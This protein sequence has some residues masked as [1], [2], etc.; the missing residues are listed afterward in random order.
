MSCPMTIVN[1]EFYRV[2][3]DEA[4]IFCCHGCSPGCEEEFL[5]KFGDR[6]S[7]DD[8]RKKWAYERKSKRIWN[9]AR[10]LTANYEL[11]RL[12]KT[13]CIME[14]GTDVFVEGADVY[15]S[16]WWPI[17]RDAV[18]KR[19]KKICRICGHNAE[20][21]RALGKWD[22]EVH[23]I[24]PRHAGGSDHPYNLITLCVACHDRE[25]AHKARLDEN[26]MKL[27]MWGEIYE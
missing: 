19:D 11:Q 24:M 10:R 12:I 4:A 6:I 17:V 21:D 20:Y 8:L 2:T 14:E 25:H 9:K 5:Q 22:I 23:H 7:L 16:Y 13:G 27:E 26:Q 18:L 3:D 15:G 1:C